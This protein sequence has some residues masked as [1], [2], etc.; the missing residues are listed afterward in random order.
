MHKHGHKV[1]AAAM[2]VLAAGG[3]SS[4]GVGAAF[5]EDGPRARAEG[6][7]ATGGSVFQ[8]N[9]AQSSRQNNNCANT[10]ADDDEEPPI[11]TLN[12]AR[13][14]AKCVTV[15]D[16]FNKFVRVHQGPAVAEGGSGEVS[17]AQQ[18]TAQRGRQNNNCADSNAPGLLT[19]DGGKVTAACIDRDRSH[20]K[21]SVTK[22]RGAAATSG[23]GTVDVDQQIVAQEGR[24]NNNCSSP[25]DTEITVTGGRL[26]GH[27]VNKDGSLSKYAFVHGGGAKAE[28]GSTTGTNL[29][30][31]TIAQEG[32]QNNSCDNPN[33]RDL[34]LV[35][36]RVEAK[37]RNKDVSADVHTFYRGRGAEASGGSGTATVIQQNAAQEGRQN[38]YCHNPNGVT[39]DSSVEVTG[40]RLSVRCSNKDGSLNYKAL[41]KGGGARAEGGSS[42][43]GDIFQR[44]IAQE[45][46]QNNICANPN[47][48]D[49]TL[50]GS[51]DRTHCGTT[52][53]SVNVRTA[54][55][56]G[57][58]GAEGGSSV[59]GLFQQ[60]VAQEGRQNNYCANPNSL[61]LTLSSS[62]NTTH[63]QATDASRNFKSVNR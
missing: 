37:C 20:N 10:N 32:R 53:H 34:D 35:S 56:G 38:N 17:V 45:G 6:G 27:C 31:Q 57:G 15:D 52:D 16:S 28:G 9:S 2:V 47:G 43:T 3:W 22:T 7:S 12:G 29:N 62:R 25:N 61:T 55:F 33:D 42:T 59:L 63:C 4:L 36:G 8:Q 60:N 49:A 46:K 44:N 39:D 50:T 23:S 18:N 51:R 58:A 48:G 26:S 5:A 11:V 14:S 40:S 30:T 19:V 41:V 21:G 24:Q 1:A 54:D 13:A